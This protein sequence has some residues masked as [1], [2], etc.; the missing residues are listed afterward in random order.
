[1]REL[2]KLILLRRHQE[3][4]QDSCGSNLL[5]IL[6]AATLRDQR[7][8]SSYHR[9]WIIPTANRQTAEA[10]PRPHMFRKVSPQTP[11]HTKSFLPQCATSYPINASFI[12]LTLLV[13]IRYPYSRNHPAAT[14]RRHIGR[15]YS[16]YRPSQSALLLS[17]TSPVPFSSKH[18][19]LKNTLALLGS[20]SRSIQT[21]HH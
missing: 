18:C 21:L 10:G 15:P 20:Q 13:E 5:C 3:T 14:T 11:Y 19:I 9:S 8:S 7:G 17:T 1:L 16:K 2:Q 12:P 4:F 6:L